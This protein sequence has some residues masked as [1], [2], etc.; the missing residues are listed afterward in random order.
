MTLTHEPTVSVDFTWALV[1]P[2]PTCDA[3]TNKVCH[4]KKNPDE[5]YSPNFWVH[6]SRRNLAK[7]VSTDNKLKGRVETKPDQIIALYLDGDGDTKLSKNMVTDIAAAAAILGK[8]GKVTT[9]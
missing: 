9:S 1:V 8:Y 7:M 4:T 5:T 2:C 3:P 6:V